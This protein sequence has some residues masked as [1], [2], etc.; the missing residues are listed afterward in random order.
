MISQESVWSQ[1]KHGVTGKTEKRRNYVN[2]I[3]QASNCHKPGVRHE[4]N[5]HTSTLFSL[6]NYGFKCLLYNAKIRNKGFS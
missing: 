4:S 2:L 6:G 5:T 1:G 3:N